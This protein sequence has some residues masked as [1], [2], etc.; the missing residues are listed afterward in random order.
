MGLISA[1]TAAGGSVLA[2][3]WREYFYCEA[4]P[5]DILATKGVKRTGKKSSNT[6]GTDNVISNGSIVAV[7]DGQFM[8]IVEQG[9]VVEFCAEPGEFVWDSSTEPT[10]LY[11]GF[12]KGLLE[13]FKLFGKRFTFG[14]DAAKDQRIYYFNTKEI[15][16]NKYGTPA[17]VPFR[18][19]DKNIGLDMDIAI[20]CNGE[21]SYRLTD[22]LAFYKNVCGNISADF[23]RDEIDSQLK[24]ELMTALQ[25]AFARISE[26]G[27]RYSALPNHTFE[28]AEALN[29]VLTEKWHK[30]RGLAVASFGINSMKASDEDEAMIKQLQRTA[31]YRDPSMAGAKLVDAQAE[32]MV[33]AAN[34]T[35]AGSVMAF[36]GM[37]MAANAGGAQKATDFFA[38]SQQQKDAAPAP[39]AAPA[40]S[41]TCAC[42]QSNTGK[43]CASCGKP[44]GWKCECGALNM[45]K[46]CAEC[47]KKKPADEIQY[48]CD[49]CGW[50]PKDPSKPPRFCPECGDPFDNN[51]IKE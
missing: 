46:F 10:M 43:F 6:K 2:D 20:R 21:F 35:S 39:A 11:G 7:N 51:D 29:G 48:R 32:A 41:W 45:G 15:M 23:S 27:I 14:G 9:A 1:A 16:G 12:G 22:P 34:N 47:G 44:R 5:F 42:G 30:T 37:N 49:K 38:M 28:I 4:M 24:S 26:M 3:Q 31:V 13:S 36:A 8:M 40:G 19:V 17:P 18:V 50:V 25:P 33:G